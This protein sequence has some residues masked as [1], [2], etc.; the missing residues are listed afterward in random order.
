[1]QLQLVPEYARRTVAP[2]NRPLLK[3]IGNKQK[4][5]HEIASHFPVEFDTYFEPFVGSGGVLGTLAPVKAVGSDSF[6]PLIEIWQTLR[7][8]PETIKSWYEIRW[9]ALMSGEKKVGYEQIKAS[10]NASPNG[11]DLLFLSR[12]CYGGVVRFRQSDGYMSTPCGPHQ[13]ISPKSFSRR[14]DEWHLRTA[15]AS[16]FHMDYEEAMA[17]AKPGDLVYCDPP[18]S[19]SQSILYGAQTFSLE[20]L[21]NVIERC[22]SRGVFVALSID[23]TKR[24]GD[25]ICDLPLPDGLFNRELFIDIGKSMLKRLQM[26]GRSLDGE[27]V[28]DRL[29]LTY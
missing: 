4:C 7:D 24:S 26:G 27:T 28:S 5:A 19:H 23:G 13:P 16:Y 9:R 2:F 15:G 25:L 6:R 10:Y 29:L 22:K 3:W 8:S 11:A 17:L 20:H 12:S 1:M 21:L 18:Y 14:V